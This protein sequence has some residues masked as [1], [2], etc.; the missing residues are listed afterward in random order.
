[1]ISDI[2]NMEG[3]LT[4]NGL[5]INTLSKDVKKSI[6]LEFTNSYEK[7]LFKA[8]IYNHL[9]IEYKIF[10]LYAYYF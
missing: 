8:L 5:Y 9:V 7:F 4:S 3:D 1:M 2:T 10:K 6:Y